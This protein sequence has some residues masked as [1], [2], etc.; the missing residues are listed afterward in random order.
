MSRLSLVTLSAIAFAALSHGQ[1]TLDWSSSS[2]SDGTTTG[3]F[4]DLRGA[5]GAS[6]LVTPLTYDFGNGLTALV[7]A[8]LVTPG[9]K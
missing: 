7:T 6:A 5:A 3:T 4:N 2:W 8:S 9:V 1:V